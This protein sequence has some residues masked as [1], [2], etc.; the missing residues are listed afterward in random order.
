MPAEKPKKSRKPTKAILV[1]CKTKRAG[2]GIAWMPDEVC[3]I[4]QGEKGGKLLLVGG[5]T[6][7]GGKDEAWPVERIERNL[8]RIAEEWAEDHTKSWTLEVR[9]L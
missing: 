8:G 4:L 9:P 5:W 2:K 6:G 1:A 3:V 7:S